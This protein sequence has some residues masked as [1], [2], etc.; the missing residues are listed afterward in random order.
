MTGL[1]SRSRKSTLFTNT[2]LI[3]KYRRFHKLIVPKLQIATFVDYLKVQ[4]NCNEDTWKTKNQP[5]ADSILL[6]LF[7]IVSVDAMDPQ[8]RFNDHFE[9][10]K[11]VRKIV[12]MMESSTVIVY[13]MPSAKVV[14]QHSWVDTFWVNFLL[15][16]TFLSPQI[17]ARGYKNSH[18]KLRHHS[19]RLENF[20]DDHLIT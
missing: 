8:N 11:V 9:N 15:I 5:L 17:R 7:K 6:I 14:Y 10:I 12:S 2:A 18:R 13:I 4:K 1:L 3:N 19:T 20:H 16:G